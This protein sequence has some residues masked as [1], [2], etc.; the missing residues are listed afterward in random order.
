MNQRTRGADIEGMS[1]QWGNWSRHAEPVGSTDPPPP[2][3]RASPRVL[4]ATVLGVP[5]APLYGLWLSYAIHHPPR[6]RRRKAPAEFGLDPDELWIKVPSANAPLH[7]WLCRGDPSRVVVLGHGIG[8]DKSHCLPYAQ[9]LNQSGYTVV[10]FDF[11]NH[12]DSF[13]DRGILRFSRRFNED[14]STVAAH[15]RAMAD[16]PDARIALYGV[17]FSAFP[18]LHSL[19][20]LDG[21]VGAMICDSG[22][23][24]DP[25]TTARNFLRSGFLP[26]PRL[27]RTGVAMTILEAIHSRA[28]AVAVGLPD[29]WR[30][31]PEQPSYDFP[32]LF[33]GGDADVVVPADELRALAESYPNAESLIVPE[34]EHMRTMT[35]APDRYVT[36]VLDFLARTLGKPADG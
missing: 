3:Q 16:Y 12:G 26:I 15:V 24:P 9:F 30:P 32:M 5:L 23:G 36:T 7:G 4:V 31:A 17:S 6:P 13:R 14:V 11:R 29:D 22:P 20:L 35:V 28:T 8:L 21:A 18:M 19:T 33:I 1:R 34:A 2:A 25:A 27:L 10:L